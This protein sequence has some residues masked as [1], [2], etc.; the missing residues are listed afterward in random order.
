MKEQKKEFSQFDQPGQV[1]E[2]DLLVLFRNALR[3]FLKLWWVCLLLMAFFG[4]VFFV[5]GIVSYEPMYRAQATFTVETYQ[6]QDGYTF[7]YDN[8][9]A[10]QMAKTFP[11]LLDSD[12][13]LERVKTDLGVTYLNGTPSA[14]VIE[15]SNLFTI[16]V[17]SRNPQDAY[18]ILQAMINNYPIV[19]EY[20]IGRV[21]VNMIAFPELPTAPYN[22]NS[23][24]SQ[25]VKGAL[26]GLFVS[27]LVVVAAAFLRNTVQKASDVEDKLYTPCLGSV[28]L[29]IPK[30]NRKNKD[31]KLTI[32][33]S[34]V[35]TPFK[36]SFRGISLH[37]ASVMEDKKVLL[38]T[39]TTKDEGTSTVTLNLA[40]ALADQGKRV[41]V[42]DG[43]FQQ[44]I[45]GSTV[46]DE[47]LSDRCS[48][49]HLLHLTK[50]TQVSILRCGRS[51]SLRERSQS[52]PKLA[53]LIQAAKQEMDYILIDAPSCQ[54]LAQVGY[55]AELAEAIVYVIRHDSTKLTQIMNCF[56]DLRQYDARI[57]GCILTGV[58]A[59]AT[60][61]GYG[62]GYG[63]GGY[64]YG[65]YGQYGYGY[66][67]NKAGKRKAGE[68]D[69]EDL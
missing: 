8:R 15:N 60:G 54:D 64:H 61:Y 51:L 22:E 20:V 68:D 43:D 50:D 57:I 26:A 62:Y 17:V 35:G 44:A 56:E 9:T 27:L 32:H 55:T 23:Y 28:P 65:R 24:V 29:V 13:L 63:Y 40:Y 67:E 42:L 3:S 1:A 47:Y 33:S 38:C 59:S 66:G 52:Q 69:Y 4:A 25:G 21:R 53:E 2:F 16:S 5:H 46:L 14:N 18:D 11:Y 37:V 39:S 19:A 41:M 6:N 31:L 45:T 7:Y 30:G 49:Q 10:A 48:L 34:K 58:R 12:L 36:E